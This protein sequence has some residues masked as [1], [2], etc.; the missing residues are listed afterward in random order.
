M[1]IG[2]IS[3]IDNPCCHGIFI[4][5]EREA[6]TAGPER[7]PQAQLT[8][9]CCDDLRFFSVYFSSLLW[10]GRRSPKQKARTGAERGPSEPA[11]YY[12]PT[13]PPQQG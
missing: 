3:L 4:V 6:A 9:G 12:E 13:L 5:V 1:A 11:R 8:G 7:G 10:W 2:A